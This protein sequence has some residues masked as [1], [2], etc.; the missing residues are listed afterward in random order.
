[1]IKNIKLIL[2]LIVITSCWACGDRVE[3]PLTNAQQTSTSLIVVDTGDGLT[4]KEDIVTPLLDIFTIAL[5]KQPDANVTIGPIISSNTGEVTV[6][7]SS[8]TFTTANWNIPQAITV[9]GVDDLANDGT[10][11]VTISL[12]TTSSTDP[13]WNSIA[14]SSVTVY[15]LDDE[16]IA[17]PGVLVSAGSSNLVTEAGTTC[18][19]EVVLKS[20][21]TANVTI[22]V[23]VSDATEGTITAPFAGASGTLTFTNANWSTPQTITVQGADDAL[24]DGNQP[25]TI[26]L[27]ATA[28]ADPVY[29]GTFNPP[30]VTFTNIDNDAAGV[31][32]SAGSTMLVSENLNTSSFVVVLN[33]QPTNNV[34]IPVSVSDTTEAT[35]TT[36]FAGTSGTLTFTTANWN[37]PQTITVQGVNDNEAD[38]NQAFT[39]V[40]GATAS[41]DPAYNGTFNPADVN[42]IN[43]DDDSAGIT[44]NMGD[45]VITKENPISPLSDTFQVVLNSQP[46]ADVYIGV[47]V[48]DATEGTIT[49]PFAGT[50]GTL[51]FTTANWNTPQ[52]VTVQGVDDILSDGMITYTITLAAA[53]STDPVYNG[54]NPSDVTVK[55][56]DNESIGSIVIVPDSNYVTSESGTSSSFNVFLS[57]QPAANVTIGG[58]SGIRSLDSTE[59]TITSPFAGTGTL[60]F[61]PTNWSVPQK[62]IV[63]GTAND[64]DVVDMSYS[65]DLGY[66]T[67]TDSYWDG[68]YGG[69]IGFTNRNDYATAFP[70]GYVWSTFTPGSD[71]FVPITGTNILF[72]NI[73]G[74]AYS[75]E[76]EG[77]FKAPIGFHFHYLNNYYNEIII[78]T[79]GLASFD[80]NIVE[81]WNYSLFALAASPFLVLAPWWCDMT[82]A[83]SSASVFYETT[84]T[85]PNRTFTVEWRNGMVVGDNER[86]TF[87]L[88]LYES[89][90]VIKFIYGGTTGTGGDTTEAVWGL[91]DN[92]GGADNTYI[93]AYDGSS[94]GGPFYYAD[95]FFP[96][97]AHSVE[98]YTVTFT[99]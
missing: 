60:V 10:Q 24:V 20:Q 78:Y 18:S 28:S 33:S 61:T 22:P 11:A 4:T 14:I 73:P 35:I 75:S 21:P 29:S 17:T 74:S 8:V 89:G 57:A 62:I 27:G 56:L 84:G 48:G 34:T 45:G 77:Y 42:F 38:G 93:E 76:D 87:Q 88:K 9:T 53:T 81:T 80:T 44:V 37:T 96:T 25:F 16:I 50:S 69:S 91:K 46:T 66:A 40:L 51:T 65:I 13:N 97:N 72:N 1:V 79:N 67:S 71:S 3:N 12:G 39:V 94:T 15:N 5:T 7:P 64:G 6:S 82:F 98:G 90:N 43:V 31:T 83:G 2:L 41:A 58:I 70:A 59:G 63:T 55:N 52:T 36:P 30:D 99:P 47:T 54:I 23:S 92:I 26:T 49:T 86:Y 19:F 95:S 32:V 85:S 68:M